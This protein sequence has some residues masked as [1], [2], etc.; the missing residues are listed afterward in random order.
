MAA[1]PNLP[2]GHFKR[3][4]WDSLPKPLRD[5]VISKRAKGWWLELE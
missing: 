2:N 4:L 3:S 1:R 5:I